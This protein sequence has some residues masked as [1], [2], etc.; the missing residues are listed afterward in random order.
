M[1]PTG[2]PKRLVSA[3]TPFVRTP[4]VDLVHY[5]VL[6]LCGVSRASSFHY[7]SQLL[8]CAAIMAFVD[9]QDLLALEAMSSTESTENC[10]CLDP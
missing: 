9:L 6:H 10:H 4:F 3:R 5:D 2:V 1:P 8:N 7:L